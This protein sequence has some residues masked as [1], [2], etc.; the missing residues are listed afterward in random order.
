M[1]ALACGA[2]L[3]DA[4]A[5]KIELVWSFMH[6]DENALHLACACQAGAEFLLT[7]DDNFLKAA[8]RLK[9]DATTTQSG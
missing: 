5:G 4:E 6:E 7:C 3:A 9:L 2:V 1:K 8:S